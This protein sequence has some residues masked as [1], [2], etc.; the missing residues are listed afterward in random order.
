MSD[1]TIREMQYPISLLLEIVERLS[2]VET[3]L[4]NTATKS[5]FE[6]V[7]LR[8]ENA[9]TKSDFE[10]ME[11]NQLKWLL[12]LSL[13]VSLSWEHSSNIFEMIPT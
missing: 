2:K 1:E 12:L 9:A 7:E 5:D 13:L 6:K 10:K 3:R 11:T 4:E 8:L